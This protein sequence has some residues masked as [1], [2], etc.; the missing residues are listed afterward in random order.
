VLRDTLHDETKNGL[1]IIHTQLTNATVSTIEK[2]VWI[3]IELQTKQQLCHSGWVRNL[4][5]TFNTFNTFT[6][7]TS[8]HTQTHSTTSTN[9]RETLTS[10]LKHNRPTHDIVNSPNALESHTHTRTT[11]YSN[12]VTRTHTRTHT[13]PHTPT[14]TQS[15]T[16]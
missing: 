2:G 11:L 4:M 3:P 15:W 5:K 6:P 10:G 14:P 9:T 7:S 8:Q 16:V 12:R 13:H 1:F